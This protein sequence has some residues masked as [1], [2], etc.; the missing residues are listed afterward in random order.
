MEGGHHRYAPVLL[1][2]ATQTGD[3]GRHFSKQSLNGCPTQCH[4][5]LGLDDLDLPLDPREAGFHLLGARLAIAVTLAGRVRAAL[6]DVGDVNLV[7]VQPGGLD[8][9]CEQLAGRADKRLAFLVLVQP[10]RLADEHQL[11]MD[12]ANTE[13]DLRSRRHEMAAPDAGHR[14]V[15]QLG[16]RGFFFGYRVLG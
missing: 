5:H 13:H 2:V 10:R 6:E 15:T 4:H 14:L 16:H 12:G 8:N 11:R 9:L 3:A 7:T 1:P